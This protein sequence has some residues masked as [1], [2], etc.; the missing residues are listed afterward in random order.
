[1]QWIDSQLAARAAARAWT[2]SRLPAPERAAAR[3]LPTAVRNDPLAVL[4]PAVVGQYELSAVTPAGMQ[5]RAEIWQR[6]HAA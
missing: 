1:V 5:K 2:A 3:L 6:V 4:D